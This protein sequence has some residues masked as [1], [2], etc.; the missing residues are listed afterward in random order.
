MFLACAQVRTEAY[1]RAL[2]G[3]PS[4]VQ[5]A[6]VLDVGCGTGILSL[7]AARAGAKRVVGVD[8]SAQIVAV[9][10][11]VA[12]DNGYLKLAGTAARAGAGAGAGASADAARGGDSTGGS[13]ASHAPG[14]ASGVPGRKAGRPVV[15]F[16]N[17]KVEE[18]PR[19]LEIR[20]RTAAASQPG[21][22][23]S[24]FQL[25]DAA[26]DALVRGSGGEGEGAWEEG[27][28]DSAVTG[29]LE[30]GSVDVIVSEW[31][32]YGLLC[33]SMLQSVIHARDTWL[34]PGGAILPDIAK[35]VRR[36]PKH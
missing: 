19:H 27:G 2:E 23:A 31:M 32:G 10:R 5:G 28:D 11:R 9:A 4:L 36:N 29:D 6:V 34:K 21:E 8:A 18:L 12:R 15:S 20:G 3:N 22:A 17:C 35:I 13:A 26:T 24:S 16:I 33:E 7:F 30:R 25:T 1:Q 14:D